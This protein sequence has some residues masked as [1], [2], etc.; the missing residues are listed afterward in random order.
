MFV[1]R[2]CLA[3]EIEQQGRDQERVG[4]RHAVNGLQCCAKANCDTV[5]GRG[6]EIEC[7]DADGGKY[8][9]FEVRSSAYLLDG[10]AGA[11]GQ[12]DGLRM[13]KLI[14][15]I[16]RTQGLRAAYAVSVGQERI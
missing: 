4:L 10:E 12:N 3:I 9:S 14:V 16:R 15:P 13:R 8:D 5:F 11:W 2:A 6:F 7:L 1:Q